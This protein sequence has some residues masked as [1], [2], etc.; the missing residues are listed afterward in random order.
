[1]LGALRAAGHA[2]EPMTMATLSL[3]DQ[4]HGGGLNGTVAMA[5]FAGVRRARGCW[6]PAAGLA[7]RGT[8]AGDRHGRR[9][10]GPADERRPLARG[11]W[12]VGMLV[13]ADRAE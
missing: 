13:R 1:M 10:A 7:A 11:G 4:P 9:H 5:E 8:R 12:L 2:T 3:V 6:T